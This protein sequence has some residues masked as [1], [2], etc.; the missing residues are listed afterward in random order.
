M[1]GE[2]YICLAPPE[3]AS[4]IDSELQDAIRSSWSAATSASD[5]VW[6]PENPAAGH[7]DVTSLLIRE[8]IGGD[9]KMAQVFRNG[10]LS[11]HHFWNVLP[12][13]S[14]IDLT[15]SQFDGSET[16]GDPTLMTP[17]FFAAA[18][19]MNPDLVR[20]LDLFRA[21]IEAFRNR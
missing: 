8:E 16:F 5:N 10:E 6:A 18:G 20:R 12:D 9:L 2:D 11:E 4:V 13:G 3:G 14:E 19:P 1:G 15:S 17:D 21:V 7:C